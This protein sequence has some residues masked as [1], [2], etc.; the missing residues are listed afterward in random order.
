MVGTEDHGISRTRSMAMS[1]VLSPWTVLSTAA[2]PLG[3]VARGCTRVGLAHD[4]SA[5]AES[6][7]MALFADKGITYRILDTSPPV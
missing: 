4:G 3:R 2:G 5:R 1:D 6:A 7:A